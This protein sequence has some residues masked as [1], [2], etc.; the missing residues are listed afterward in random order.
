[1]F[2]NCGKCTLLRDLLGREPI[3]VQLDEIMGYV[4]NKTVMVM[5]GGGS[6]GSEL[7]R[8]IAAH[9]PKPLIIVDI[10]ENNAYDIQQ[11]LIRKYP[12]LHLVVLIA[13]VRNT[14]RMNNIFETVPI[15]CIMQQHIS[16]FLLWR[17]AQMRQLKTMC[18]ALIR[19]QKRQT[20]T[21]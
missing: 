1:M 7:C 13:S 10:Y 3:E 9:N 6:I 4:Q 16:M 15:L 12:D 5:G 8:Q 18:L 21:E 19:Q 20:D 2:P 17:T 14:H 11:E